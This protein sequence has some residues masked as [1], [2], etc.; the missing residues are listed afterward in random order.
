ME[1]SNKIGG[2]TYG[3]QVDFSGILAVKFCGITTSIPVDF[4][5]IPAVKFGGKNHWFTSGFQWKTMVLPVISTV[6]SVEN[7][8]N[9]TKLYR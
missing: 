5:G 9:T 8:D 7:S 6:I 3:I 1:Y 4:S 2:I